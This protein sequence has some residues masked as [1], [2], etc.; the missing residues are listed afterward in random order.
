MSRLISEIARQYDFIEIGNFQY[1]GNID[2]S[3]YLNPAKEFDDKAFDSQAIFPV[4]N[5][6]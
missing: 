5:A 1:D 4:V 3:P 2:W 6:I